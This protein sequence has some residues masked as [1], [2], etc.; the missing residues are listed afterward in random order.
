MWDVIVVGA[1]P[2]GS[3]AAFMLAREGYRTLLV[4]KLGDDGCKIGEVL[5][6]AAARLLRALGL[7][8]PE[9][10][11]PHASIRGTLT[12]WDSDALVASDA[13]RDPYGP[14][15]RLDRK[16]FDADL[17]A[18]AMAAGATYRAV[19]MRDVRRGDDDWDVW[20]S[21]GGAERARWIVDAS[22]RRAAV[23]RQLGVSRIRDIR[24]IAFYTVGRSDPNIQFD[25]TVIEAAPEGWWYA[26]RLPSGAAVAGFHTDARMAAR[27]HADPGAWTQALAR[28]AHVARMLSPSRFEQPACALDARGARLAQ[29]R[30]AGWIACGDAAMCFDPISGQGIFSALHGGFAC[31]T[32]VIGALNREAR[33]LDEYASQMNDVWNI[34]RARL[35]A[36]YRN[37]RRWPAAG[38]WSCER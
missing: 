18:A 35:R 37:E 15:W 5:P 4:D 12:S 19:D 8:A 32:A 20:F 26:A 11:G 25:R 17:R 33:K 6:G 2:A 16:R 30:G 3:V 21:A 36:I 27:L 23:G 29:V 31:G 1:G 24:L 22:G 34:Y 9:I 38:F 7:P 28:T 14:G 13:I 10:G